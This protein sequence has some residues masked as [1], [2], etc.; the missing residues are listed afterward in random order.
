MP[1]ARPRLIGCSRLAVLAAI[2]A[3]CLGFSGVA[4]A[5]APPDPNTVGATALSHIELN[6]VL[7]TELTVAPGQDVKIKARWQDN[8]T[9]CPDC[10]DFVATAFAG[11]PVAGCIEFE[12]IHEFNPSGEG[13]VDLG[14]APTKAGRYKVVAHFEET[15]TCG[16]GWNASDSKRYQVIAR[17]TVP[18]TKTFIYTGKEQEF[19]VPAEV[20]SVHVTAVGGAGGSGFPVQNPGGAGGLGAVVSANLGVTPGHTLYVE[21]GGEGETAEGGST[22]KGGFNGGGNESSTGGGGGGGASDVRTESRTEAKT[23]ESRLLVAAG[24]GGGGQGKCGGGSGHGGAGGNAQEAGHEGTGECVGG[25]SGGGAGTSE[26]GG[27]GGS[28]GGQ[29]GTLG[30]GGGE[31][32]GGG[33]GG[34]GLYGGGSGGEEVSG[35]G[36]GGGSNLVPN[37]GESK[38]AEAKQATSVTITYTIPVKPTAL[39]T[40]LSGE[41]KSNAQI[42]VKEGASVTDKATVSGENSATA[43]GE[44]T[45]KVYADKECKQL[46]KEAGTVN[47]EEGSA[48]ASEAQTLSPGTYYWQAEYFGDEHNEES[49]SECGAEVL[50]VLATK[51]PTTLTT[52]LSGEG[53]KGEKIAVKEGEGVSDQATLSGEN[54]ATASGTVTYRIY[55]D[56][57]CSVLV[58]QAGT[59]K[60]TNGSVPASGSQTLAGGVSYFW[61]AEYSGDEHNETSKSTCGA[62]I[63]T[64]LATCGKT[65]VGKLSDQL[66]ANQKRVNAC[67][68]PYAAGVREL[69]MYLAPTTHKG[70]QVIKGIV[71]ADNKGRPGARLGV[72]EQLT[73]SSSSAAGWY[74][75][76]FHTPLAVPVGNCWIGVITGQT[77]QVAGERYDSVKGA[78]DYNYNSYSSGPSSAFGSFS[79]TN[80]QM[81]LYAAFT[82][83]TA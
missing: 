57:E 1:A 3:A 37:G 65:S 28:P 79:L 48:A 50:T 27:A 82:R 9:A 23:L 14:P 42:A 53:H 35:G 66:I 52:S 38:L 59:V 60:V 30:K 64:V 56:S 4:R 67:K 51:K 70:T 58:K 78:E 62:E 7:G 20:T 11:N 29:E 40:S 31:A 16:E 61:Q 33:G 81:S 43:S 6:G 76:V 34:G 22:G 25:G 46:V 19:K 80:E 2:A 17:V 74:R 26:R 36:G 18:E 77:T 47:V 83:Q 73:F 32:F 55:A 75:L 72:T 12:G 71:Y 21:V 68:L 8:N 69:V 63:E 5:A 49:V 44:V 24:G 45:Y 39:T 41:G 15:L 10:F 13:E 54:A